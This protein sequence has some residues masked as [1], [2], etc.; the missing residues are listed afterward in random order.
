MFAT[1]LELGYNNINKCKNEDVCRD[2]MHHAK[3]RGNKEITL[4]IL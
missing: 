2:G 4:A 1:W 3:Y